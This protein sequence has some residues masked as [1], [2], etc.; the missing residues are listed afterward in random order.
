MRVMILAVLCLLVPTLAGGQSRVVPYDYRVDLLTR[1]NALRQA[2]GRAGLVLD[3]RLNRVAQRHAQNM[4]RQGRMDHVLDG[5]GV[6]ERVCAEGLCRLAVGENIAMGQR[7][8]ARVTA[9]WWASPGHQA[10]ILGAGWSRVV[11]GYFRDGAG[12]A[13]WCAVF[14]R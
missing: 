9:S 7:D 11:F 3:E 14:A 2:N 13:W 6:G 1:H 12:R 5:Q 8:A 4:A 10:S